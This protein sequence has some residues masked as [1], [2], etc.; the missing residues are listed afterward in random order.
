MRVCKAYAHAVAHGVVPTL[1]LCTS[2]TGSCAFSAPHCIYCSINVYHLPPA[3]NSNPTC[4][5]SLSLSLSL[6][7]SLCA[8]TN[9]MCLSYARTQKNLLAHQTAACTAA[10]VLTHTASWT[11]IAIGGPR[12]STEGGSDR[13]PRSPCQLQVR[14][15]AIMMQTC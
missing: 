5:L 8:H 14:V 12:C 2:T 11:D 1:P 6:S 15:R 4:V 13:R 7:R 10:D 9:H 3:A